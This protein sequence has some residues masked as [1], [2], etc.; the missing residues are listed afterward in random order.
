MLDALIIRKVA[1]LEELMAMVYEMQFSDRPD[2]V[3]AIQRYAKYLRDAMETSKVAG[4]PE[5]V[6][7]SLTEDF[8]V[9]FDR[10]EAR[11]RRNHADRRDSK[12]I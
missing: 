1:M 4:V 8:G 7:I 3:A 6:T 11:L 9:F 2:P 12:D 10:V 5:D